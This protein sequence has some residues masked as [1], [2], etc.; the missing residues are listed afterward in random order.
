[1][2]ES[3]IITVYQ[4]KTKSIFGPVGYYIKDNCLANGEELIPS[5]MQ[6]WFYV[7]GNLDSLVE[8]KTT[9]TNSR[10]ELI[11][12]DLYNEKIP[13]LIDDTTKE[14][15]KPLLDAELYKYVSDSVVT[16]VEL[17]R[18]V[19]KL[20]ID[21][22]FMNKTKK[23]WDKSPSW[24]RDDKIY[25]TIDLVEYHPVLKCMTPRPL[26]DLTRP[27]RIGQSSL[28]IMLVD[29]IAQAAPVNYRITECSN[30][31]FTVVYASDKKRLM[32][33]E[34]W[35]NNSSL[36]TNAFNAFYVYGDNYG[37]LIE[38]V[39]AFGDKVIELLKATDEAGLTTA[40][41]EFLQGKDFRKDKRYPLPRYQGNKNER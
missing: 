26:L 18:E 14:K 13:M 22:D 16:N 7:E 33:W 1:M 6:D 20:D 25:F 24:S 31:L 34:N 15:Y 40:L 37:E 27:C 9:K 17:E 5:F 8:L 21:S 10:Y 11:N 38:K 32:K 30:T 4:T 39:H 23:S 19:I 29:H 35:T 41:Y 3:K 2:S 28:F 12:K 36:F